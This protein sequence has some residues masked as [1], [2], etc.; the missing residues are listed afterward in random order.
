MSSVS[1]D[2]MNTAADAREHVP[3]SVAAGWGVGTLATTTMLNGASVVLLYFLVTYVKIEPVLAGALLF[4]SKMLDVVTDPPMGMIS[5]RTRSRYGRRRPWMLGAAF[6]CGLSFAMLFNVPAGGMS[7]TLLYVG[8]ALA[9]YAL[10]Y[11]AFQVPY[12]AMPAEMTDDSHQ[13]TKI[14]SW[15]VFFMT[16]GNLAGMGAVPA[17]V[18]QLGGDRAAYQQMGIVIGAFIAVV[19]LSCFFLTRDARQTSPADSARIPLAQQLA[20]LGDNQPLLILMGTKVAIYIGLASNI[21]VA[22]FFF[23]GVLKFGGKMLGLFLALQAL[24]SIVCLPLAAWVSKRVGKKAA[25]IA[26]LV[27]F[28]CIVLTW[29]VASPDEPM[30]VFVGRAILLGMFGAGAHLYGQSMLIDTFAWDYKLTGVRREG[31]LSAAF[32]FV[33]KACMAMGPLIV[34]VLFSAMGFDKELA[35]TAEQSPSAVTAMYLGFVWIPVGMQVM[36]VT[37]LAFYRLTDAD[38]SADGSEQRTR[39]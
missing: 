19:M 13:R 6:F 35:P 21:A 9:L 1:G 14:M 12:M 26:S 7:T 23:S 8:V 2:T 39:Q 32:S 25:Y 18:E 33:E 34:G 24:T 30:A 5:D 10:S 27:G 15:R 22:M 37:L 29:L 3:A 20:W 28:C 31:V 4:G 36:S 38:L 16:L 11:T 17:L